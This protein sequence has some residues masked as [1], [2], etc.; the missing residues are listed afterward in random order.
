M[1]YVHY[2]CSMVL[3]AH[4]NCNTMKH[5]IE[6]CIVGGRGIHEDCSVLKGIRDLFYN[7]NLKLLSDLMHAA[8]RQIIM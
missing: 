3:G 8:N 5:S 6:I 2:K 4:T 7:V 1:F